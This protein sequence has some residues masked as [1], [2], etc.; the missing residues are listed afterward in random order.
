MLSRLAHPNLFFPIS[1][2][3]DAHLASD[4]VTY[5]AAGAPY[6]QNIALAT[7]TPYCDMTWTMGAW[8]ALLSALAQGETYPD[9]RLADNPTLFDASMVKGIMGG[10]LAKLIAAA[11]ARILAN[12]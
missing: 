6:A 2:K 12:G 7:D 11:Y 4:L 10:N 3:R 9:P 5:A 8:R 1:A